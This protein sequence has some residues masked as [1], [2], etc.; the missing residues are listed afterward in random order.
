MRGLERRGERLLKQ[1][2]DEW[3]D[4]ELQKTATYSTLSKSKRIRI[5]EPMRWAMIYRC[6]V[7][8]SPPLYLSVFDVKCSFE[9]SVQISTQNVFF[10]KEN[11]FHDHGKYRMMQVMLLAKSGGTRAK[12]WR[13]ILHSAC[14]AL[15]PASPSLRMCDVASRSE[16]FVSEVVS[17]QICHSWR[18][19]NPLKLDLNW[20]RYLAFEPM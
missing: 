14:Q 3:A 18:Y 4:A 10:W 6:C 2:V 13:Q 19:K 8:P 7:Y 11:I 16:G 20:Y 15:W 1:P 17:H 9:D 5:H 12:S